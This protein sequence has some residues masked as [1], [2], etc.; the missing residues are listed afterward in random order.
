MITNCGDISSA[1]AQW[2]VFWKLNRVFD[3]Y[4][5]VPNLRVFYQNFFKYPFTLCRLKNI[6]QWQHWYLQF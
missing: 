4:C 2:T 1:L 6:M 5:D 3:A